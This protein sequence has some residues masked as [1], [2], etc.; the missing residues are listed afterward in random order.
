MVSTSFTSSYHKWALLD[1]IK[2]H[3]ISEETA[4]YAWNFDI[5]R[6]VSSVTQLLICEHFPLL[7]AQ[8]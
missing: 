4:I 3:L 5:W 2:H 8:R 7:Q 1:L 6:W